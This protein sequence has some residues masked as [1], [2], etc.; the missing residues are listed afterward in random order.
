MAGDTVR[1]YRRLVDAL[2]GVLIVEWNPL[3]KRATRENGT[4]IS[5]VQAVES[6][7]HI[8]NN[9]PTP[10]YGR[11]FHRNFPKFP[12][13]LRRAAI[14]AALGATSSYLTRYR[15]W[16]GGGRKFRQQRPPVFGKSGQWPVLY[17]ASGGAGAMIRQV[18]EVVEIKLYDATSGDWLWRR[19]TVVRRGRRHGVDGQVPLSP[20]LIVEG[21][22]L[23]LGQPY[24]FKPRKA[25]PNMPDR[26][27]AVDLGV[28]KQATCS[29]VS[30]NGTVLKRIT[31]NLGMHIDHRDK[32]AAQ[33]RRKARQTCGRYGKLS[34][35][36]CRRFYR[37]IEGINLHMA[38]TLSRQI[39]NFAVTHGAEAMVFENLKH[40]RPRGGAKRTPMKQRFHGWLHRHLIH[41]VSMSAAERGLRVV[42]VHPRG[43]SS[44]AFDGSGKVV[45]FRENYSRCLFA[46]GK[47]Y[48]CDFNASYN[49]AARGVYRLD[50][51]HQILARRAGSSPAVESGWPPCGKSSTGGPRM[52]V[53]LSNLWGVSLRAAA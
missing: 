33:I 47:E 19:A 17:T 10:R 18:G 30:R 3:A 25:G 31:F 50:S 23:C 34:G 5:D 32:L 42:F 51:Q 24:E 11:W 38:R 53:T 15:A 22:S 48:D 27:C 2:S 29:V 35:G 28:N 44:W 4:E 8:T 52:P 37:R 41:Q 7:F 40:F 36:F 26:V 39:I 45:R 6:L 12:A 21:S 9:N 46:N 14:M 20:A 43:T 1:Q 16:Q 13:Y 49:I